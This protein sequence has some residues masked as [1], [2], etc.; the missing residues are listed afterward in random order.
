MDNNTYN[1]VQNWLL[2]YEYFNEHDN[3]NKEHEYDSNKH[4]SITDS[5]FVSTSEVDTPSNVIEIPITDNNYEVLSNDEQENNSNITS[6]Y[7]VF[8]DDGIDSRLLYDVTKGEGENVKSDHIS[9]KN[10]NHQ[11]EALD[12]IDLLIRNPL[13]SNASKNTDSEPL[14]LDVENSNGGTKS[15]KIKYTKDD[16]C[17]SSI[18]S[19]I[20][21]RSY[22]HSILPYRHNFKILWSKPLKH[23]FEFTI[24]KNKVAFKLLKIF[25]TVAEEYNW[26]V[27]D[28]FVDKLQKLNNY[29]FQIDILLII[30]KI[31]FG[32]MEFMYVDCIEVSTS[33]GEQIKSFK[34]FYKSYV[35][36]YFQHIKNILKLILEPLDIEI[37]E[38]FGGAY[39]S[40]TGKHLSIRYDDSL[41]NITADGYALFTELNE[42]LMCSGQTIFE[43]ISNVNDIQGSENFL[44]KCC[45][46][47]LFE[48]VASTKSF[49]KFFINF[50]WPQENNLN[51]YNDTNFF[52][53]TN[54]DYTRRE[55]RMKVI[56]E[57][58]NHLPAC[59]L[60]LYIYLSDKHC[61]FNFRKHLINSV[62]SIKKISLFNNLSIIFKDRARASVAKL[63]SCP[64]SEFLFKYILA[65]HM[66]DETIMEVIKQLP[67]IL[68]LFMNLFLKDND[69]SK[70]RVLHSITSHATNF[71]DKLGNALAP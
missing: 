39:T 13:T 54:V 18:I 64:A 8:E 28:G 62:G 49:S 58:L 36:R 21:N 32:L 2:E 35:D 22:T 59:N 42:K 37:C 60:T 1:Y 25:D 16:D 46:S 12:S 61:R 33:D 26:L 56:R 52:I 67:K 23:I 47:S 69:Q 40:L 51:E 71:F 48:N 34:F 45:L 50:F 66:K 19:V 31:L 17:E 3:I 6:N 38:I 55:Y 70:L 43:T 30:G 57:L 15:K 7:Y 4:T 27:G 65:D 68:V 9:H 29:Y 11:R 63:P 41:H 5:G 10:S 20:E 14:I 24:D 44:N 53:L